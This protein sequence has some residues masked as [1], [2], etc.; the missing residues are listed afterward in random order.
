LF[1]NAPAPATTLPTAAPADDTNDFA[2]SNAAFPIA[3]APSKAFPA[4]DY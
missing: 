3:L 1:A 4:L 2:P